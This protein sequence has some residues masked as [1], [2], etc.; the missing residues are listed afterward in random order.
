VNDVHTFQTPEARRE[1][2]LE[3]LAFFTHNLVAPQ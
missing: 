2:A 3:S 1:L